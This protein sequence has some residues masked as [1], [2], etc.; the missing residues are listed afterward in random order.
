MNISKMAYTEAGW[1]LTILRGVTGLV[2]IGH[3]LPK[4]GFLGGP[5]LAGTAGFMESLGL[6]LPMLM[7]VL[8][9]S[10]EA[11]GGLLLVVGFMVR[12]AA[13]TLVIAMLVAT[14]MVH[15]D[16]G[17]FGAGGYQWSFLLTAAAA[18]IMIEGA[19]KLSIDWKISG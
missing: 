12:P 9:A 16:N 19:G 14:F 5:G 2:F 10:S 4:F 17:M 7:A 11:I 18:A 15:W 3:G 6:P 8:V 13:F 1:G